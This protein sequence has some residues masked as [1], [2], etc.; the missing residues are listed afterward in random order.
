MAVPLW[1]TADDLAKSARD[2]ADGDSTSRFLCSTRRLY[3]CSRGH[4]SSTLPI[5]PSHHRHAH[6]GLLPAQVTLHRSRRGVRAR[7]NFRHHLLLVRSGWSDFS[8]QCTKSIR[9]CALMRPTPAQTVHIC[10]WLVRQTLQ[11]ELRL[12]I[13]ETYEVPTDRVCSARQSAIWWR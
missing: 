3:T 8:R 2:G 13:C 1:E 4:A 10:P 12:P 7:Q 6:T 5:H 11:F 9:R